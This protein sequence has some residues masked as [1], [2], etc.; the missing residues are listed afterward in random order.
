MVSDSGS[1][2]ALEFEVIYG[3][4]LK[5]PPRLDIQ[6][7]TQLSLEEMRRVLRQ[8]RALPGSSQ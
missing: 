3:H 1:D 7:E 8:G 4:A 2:V 5:A 6:P